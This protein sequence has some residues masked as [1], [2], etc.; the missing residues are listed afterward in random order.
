MD[1]PRGG[2]RIVSKAVAMTAKARLDPADLVNT[3]IDALIRERCE[4]PSSKLLRL[5]GFC[6]RLTCRGAGKATRDN[7]KELIAHHE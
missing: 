5:A 1:D 2:S 3:G 7:L 4:L 6:S